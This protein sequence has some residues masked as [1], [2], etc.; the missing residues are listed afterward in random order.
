MKQNKNANNNKYSGK[1]A[2]GNLRQT[3]DLKKEWAVHHA[4]KMHEEA[5]QY[6]HKAAHHK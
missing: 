4:Q 1:V 2:T 3:P 6:P 5:H